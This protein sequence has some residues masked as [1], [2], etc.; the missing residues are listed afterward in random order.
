[1]ALFKGIDVDKIKGAVESGA[2]AAQKGLSNIKVDEIAKS[3]KD[4]VETGAQ[5][6]G[7]LI[8]KIKNKQVDDEQQQDQPYRDFVALLWYLAS[9]DGEITS[10][11]KAKI[12]ELA[13]SFD[14]DYEE[15]ATELVQECTSEIRVS[16]NEFGLQNAA[17]IEAQKLIETLEPSPRDAR[18][19]C[20]N[21][22]AIANSDGLDEREADFIRFVSERAGLDPV[23]FEEFRNYSD[24]IVE[25]E[26]SQEQ[27]KESDRTYSE[28]EPIMTEF[29]KRKQT[30]IE[31]AQ[32]LV[33]DK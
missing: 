22:L 25:I 28:I 10:E 11:E 12:D 14:D 2:R 33:T 24:A 1:M 19:L 3:A 29:E 20:W 13:K 32:A 5:N 17:K 27:L 18:L 15:Y 23:V 8:E 9:V 30:I 31:A 7:N 26:C 16:E 6:A 4:A 21:L